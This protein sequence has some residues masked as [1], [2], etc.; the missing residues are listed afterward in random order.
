[1]LPL[2][3]IRS[4][5]IADGWPPLVTFLFGILMAVIALYFWY[6]CCLSIART[7]RG[8]FYT[9]SKQDMERWEQPTTAPLTQERIDRPVRVQQ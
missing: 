7:K 4:E 6:S 8:N 2:L 3:S 1:M 5:A 9:V